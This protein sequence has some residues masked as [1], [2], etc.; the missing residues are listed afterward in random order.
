MNPIRVVL[1]EDQQMMRSALV[2]LIGL[3]E[4]LEV[5]GHTGRGDEAVELIVALRPDVAVLDV[6]MPGLDGLQVAA[7]VAELVPE[8]GALIVTA[9]GKPGTLQRA[10]RA[11]ARGFIVK[12]ASAGEL[13]AAIRSVARGERVIDSFLAVAALEA[14]GT[15]PTERG[16]EVARLM[17]GGASAR[18]IATA[19]HLSE[20]TIR[21]YTSNL[22]AK[23][24]ARNRLDLIRMV[25]E[26]GWV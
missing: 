16:L 19:L 8:C 7:R 11:K 9:I 20:G 23:Y 18:Q 6:D 3:E 10:L 22:M 1:A 2:S 24:G 25:R 12:H 14:G 13:F 15:E 5:V 21:N 17:A 4:D 26:Q